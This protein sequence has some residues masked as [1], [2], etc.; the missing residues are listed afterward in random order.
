MPQTQS[1]HSCPTG[2]RRSG[3]RRGHIG[4][5]PAALGPGTQESIIDKQQSKNTELTAK[6]ARSKRSLQ[7]LETS[8]PHAVTDIIRGYRG[9]A[10]R[11][12][13]HVAR[14]I[15]EQ[16]ERY[17]KEARRRDREPEKKAARQQKRRN[18]QTPRQRLQE[19]KARQKLQHA[20][21]DVLIVRHRHGDSH[22]PAERHLVLQEAATP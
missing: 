8:A 13:Q 14:V 12:R 1:G 5:Y 6:H 7:S 2:G 16:L 18:P 3:T 22:T 4:Q 19:E 11:V 20:A 9:D 10:T 15:T 17:S 21:V